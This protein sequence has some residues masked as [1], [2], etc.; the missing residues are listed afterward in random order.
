MYLREFALSYLFTQML[1]C[2]FSAFEVKSK[3]AIVKSIL[4]QKIDPQRI[5]LREAQ[6]YCAILFDDNNRKPSR[7]LYF[8][9][10]KKFV[11][12][13]DANKKFERNEIEVQHDIFGDKLMEGYW[14]K[15]SS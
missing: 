11:D 2:V 5:H 6:S 7:R 12:I 4:R 3:F 10:K 9:R 8:N 15:S 14:S 1:G 13:R